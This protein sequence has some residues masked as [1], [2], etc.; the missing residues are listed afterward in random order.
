MNCNEV[1]SLLDAHLDEELDVVN[2]AAVAAHLESCPACSAAAL[3]LADQRQQRQTLLTRHRAPADLVASVGEALRAA[4]LEANP[5]KSRWAFDGRWLALAAGLALAGTVGFVLGD[6]QALREAALGE[7]LAAHVRARITDQLTE[8]ASSDRHTVKPWFAGK[9]DFA[10][11]VVDLAADGFTLVG[12]RRERLGGRTVATLV[13]RRRQHTIDLH[14][15][16]GA[17]LSLAGARSIEGYSVLG[18]TAG[19]LNF[20]AVSDVAPGEIAAFASLL[21]RATEP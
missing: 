16:A 18:W 10:P 19:G 4:E 20:T 6:R 15:W 7:L 14:V 5:R 8:V 21:R 3:T 11:P 17:P 12:G 13:Y 2:D 9:V 1:R